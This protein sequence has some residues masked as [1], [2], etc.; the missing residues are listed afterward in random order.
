[1]TPVITF[2]SDFGLTDSYIGICRA[3]I[4]GI[5]PEATVVD[6]VHTV[7]ALDVRRGATTLADCVSVAP[8]GI[9]LAV[10]DPDAGARPG[11]AIQ[12]GGSLLV[13]PDNGL[14]LPAADALG[15]VTAARRLSDPR[16]HRTPV[17]PVFRARDVFGPVAAHLAN[18]LDPSAVG[19]ALPV[20][21][22]HRV[23]GLDPDIR[24]RRIAAPIRNVDCYGNVQL[25]VTQADLRRA[26]LDS[27]RPVRVGTPR[28]TVE[29]PRVASFSDLASGELG[30]VEDSFG[31][32]AIVAGGADA[33]N[34]LDLR[35]ADAVRLGDD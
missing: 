31:W 32:L 17:S 33:A 19:P 22:L 11:V 34:R 20:D 13:G 6:L 35:S 29:L 18:G 8:A 4:A 25:T 21:T 28:E 12:A 2:L 14:L 26:G 9:H 16:W 3:V 15:G 27:G 23:P 5:A 10:I 1:M 24:P 7:P 30:I